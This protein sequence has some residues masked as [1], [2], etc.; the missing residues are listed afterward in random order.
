MSAARDRWRSIAIS[1]M[2]PAA[3]MS[4]IS[5]SVGIRGSEEYSAN[6]PSTSPSFVKIGSDHAARIP[7]LMARSLNS[8]GQFMCVATSATMTRFLKNAA[9]PQQAELGETSTGLIAAPIYY[10]YITRELS[11]AGLI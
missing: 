8:S 5:A 2:C 9:A 3:S 10:A 1:A 11:D 6:V 4:R 7:F